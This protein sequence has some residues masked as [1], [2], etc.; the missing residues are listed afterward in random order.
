MTLDEFFVWPDLERMNARQLKVDEDFTDSSFILDDKQYRL[1]MLEGDDQS[2]KTSLLHM[3][4]L[5]FVDKYKYPV[6]VKGKNIINENL[7][8][9][10]GNA[11]SEQYNSDEREKFM[12]YNQGLKILLVDNFDE[13][14]LND[15]IKKKVI[16]QLL[17]RFHKVIITTTKNSEVFSRR[18]QMR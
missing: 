15:T 2:G 6:L 8:N 13:C 14:V 3:Y 10:V 9:I 16:D 17:D 7:D 12:Q 18:L 1:V 4:Y 5:R 11:F